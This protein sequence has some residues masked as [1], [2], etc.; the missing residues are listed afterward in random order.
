MSALP[1]T[2][3]DEVVVVVDGVELE[4]PKV[5]AEPSLEPKLN[6]GLL[7]VVVVIVIVVV[8]AAVVVVK[9]LPSPNV[10]GV[11]EAEL[12]DG[13]EKTGFSVPP[14]DVVVVVGVW[15]NE[16]V[17]SVAVVVVAHA[18]VVFSGA[19]AK[20]NPTLAVVLVLVAAGMEKLNPVALPVDVAVV[21][22]KNVTS[23]P[24]LVLVSLCD[25]GGKET[26]GV[27]I[28]A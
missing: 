9:G 4:R 22:A 18:V 6:I 21:G 23:V 26:D 24:L 11:L 1:N 5:G 14:V 19:V 27:V 20:L 13:N 3:A 7:L 28:A 16:D 25:D 12:N 17:G 2:N 15:N 8:T 10:D